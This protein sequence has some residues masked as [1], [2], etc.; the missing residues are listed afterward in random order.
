MTGP[1]WCI[2]LGCLTLF[3]AIFLLFPC[4][5]QAIR[6]F[7]RNRMMG[8]LLSTIAWAWAGTILVREPIDF[9]MP[10]QPLVPYLFAACIPL[11]WFLLDNLLA[12]RA[13]AGLA[14]LFPMP[15]LVACR[16]YESAWRLLPISISYI[17]LTAGMV[18]M[19]YPWRLRQLCVWFSDRPRLVRVSAISSF[20]LA[21]L[22]FIAATQLTDLYMDAP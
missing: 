21:V 13:W 11:S 14:M 20:I 7:P 17:A 4:A 19:F 5:P 2:I 18:V 8:I 3:K 9:I 15:L 16:D 12:C 1:T 10:I 6:A 22:L